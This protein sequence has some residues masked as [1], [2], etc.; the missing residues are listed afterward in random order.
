MG[1]DGNVAMPL[2]YHLLPVTGSVNANIMRVVAGTSPKLCRLILIP[3]FCVIA[4]SLLSVCHLFI[5]KYLVDM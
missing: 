4:K 3:Q 1:K 5:R 2:P